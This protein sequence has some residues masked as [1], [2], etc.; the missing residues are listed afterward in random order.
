M[1]TKEL[2]RKIDAYFASVTREQLYKDMVKVAVE[3]YIN[4]KDMDYEEIGDFRIVSVDYDEEADVLYITF[5]PSRKGIGIEL[6]KGEVVRID[7]YTGNI[8]GITIVDFKCKYSEK[9]GLMFEERI[10]A[11]LSEIV[12]NIKKVIPRRKG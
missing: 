9:A 3:S 12:E 1:D 6:E 7:P 4:S 10:T 2:K 11:I 5:G 8:V